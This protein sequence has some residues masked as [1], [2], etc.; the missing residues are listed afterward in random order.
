[1]GSNGSLLSFLFLNS[2]FSSISLFESFKFAISG[3]V[4][5]T[6]IVAMFW[7][8]YSMGTTLLGFHNH[9]ITF[10]AGS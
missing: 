10:T 9:I 5:M 1:L 4:R 6:Q 3:S 8:H 7:A 2:S